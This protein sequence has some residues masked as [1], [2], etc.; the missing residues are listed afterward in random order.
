M[1]S[2]ALSAAAV[3]LLAVTA[4]FLVWPGSRRVKLYSSLNL[5]NHS[6]A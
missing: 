1:R 2:I 6:L 4:V 3:A 5:F